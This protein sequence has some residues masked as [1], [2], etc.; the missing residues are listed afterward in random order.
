MHINKINYWLLAITLIAFTINTVVMFFFKDYIFGS[1]LIG[2]I[3]VI[4]LYRNN[5][6]NS[7]V[8]TKSAYAITIITFIALSLSIATYFT[9]N[10]F[11]SIVY[12]EYRPLS[13]ITKI[14]NITYI[15]VDSEDISYIQ[16]CL[17]PSIRKGYLDNVKSIK[18]MRVPDKNQELGIWLL[19][20]KEVQVRLVNEITHYQNYATLCHEILHSQWLQHGRII[21]DLSYRYVCYDRQKLEEC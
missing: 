11:G 14:E 5:I 20:G 4:M 10:V 12:E 1:V 13:N 19:G 2:I 15:N 17:I 7:K 8:T 21:D 9:I 6:K 16:N 18:F 3:L